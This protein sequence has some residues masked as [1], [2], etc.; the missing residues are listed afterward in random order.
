M[1]LRADD[2]RSLPRTG[3]LEI[4]RRILERCKESSGEANLLPICGLG[5][6]Q[7]DLYQSFL[8]QTGLLEVSRTADEGKIFRASGKGKEFLRDY[9]QIKGL[10][11]KPPEQERRR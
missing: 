1:N 7:F 10:I 9:A 6:S 3:R 5:L 2:E 11:G 4:I 8:V